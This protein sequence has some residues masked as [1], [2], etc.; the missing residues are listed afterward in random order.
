MRRYSR[1]RRANTYHF[2]WHSSA[3][4]FHLLYSFARRIHSH[5]FADFDDTNQVKMFYSVCSTLLLFV[6]LSGSHSPPNDTCKKSASYPCRW[7]RSTRTRWSQRHGGR[8]VSTIATTT[9]SKAPSITCRAP[10]TMSCERA[11]ASSECWSMWCSHLPFAICRCMR[12][13]CGST[14]EC[15]V[16]CIFWILLNFGK[17]SGSVEMRCEG[18][19]W[20]ITCVPFTSTTLNKWIHSQRPIELRLF[21]WGKLCAP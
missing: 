9:I 7:R 16:C 4:P 3:T 15:D 8:K 11:V 18:C 20:S 14:G 1:L 17:F 5:T 13:K 12:A 6:S 10:R 2:A 21:W 19:Q